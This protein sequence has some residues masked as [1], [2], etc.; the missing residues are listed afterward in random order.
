MPGSCRYGPAV[1]LVH[2]TV[3]VMVMAGVATMRVRVIVLSSVD[4]AVFF[5]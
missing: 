1:L 5:H 2:C 4:V 3:S